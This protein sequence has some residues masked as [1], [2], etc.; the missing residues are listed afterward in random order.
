MLAEIE[1]A[2]NG[3]IAEATGLRYQLLGEIQALR[4]QLAASAQE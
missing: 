1:G 4:A 2:N 3:T